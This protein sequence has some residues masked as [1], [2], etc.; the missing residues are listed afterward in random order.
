MA[1]QSRGYDLWLTAAN[2][3]YRA[4]PYDILT[5]WL[6]QGRVVPD[7]QLR[8]SGA[9]EWQRIADV[10]GF[11]A[12]LPRAELGRPDDAAEAFE[13][14]AL[15]VPVGRRPLDEDDDPDMIP[16][17]DISLVL[18]IFFMMTATIAVAGA[19]IDT[20]T[21]YYGTGL[22]TDP[23]MIW[24]GVDRSE[25]GQAVYS[26][27]QGDRPAA[28]GD[29]KLSLPQVLQRLDARIKAVG[30]GCP[31]RIAGHKRLPYGTVKQLM[32]ELEKRRGRDRVIEVKAE[33]NEK[34]S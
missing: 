18:L 32:A 8:P 7:D 30:V 11:A 5:D 23:A 25:N 19:S 31:V 10:P 29:E 2:R 17:I 12:F 15:P 6:Q 24:I 9:G 22:T 20:P 13:P 27:G 26:I 4:V 21:A 14:V 28:D 33:V 3:V 34:S 16:L 1:K